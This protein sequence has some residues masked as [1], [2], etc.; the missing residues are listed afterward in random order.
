MTATAILCM[1]AAGIPVSSS[2]E[3]VGAVSEATPLADSTSGEALGHV[4]V[5][6][7]PHYSKFTAIVNSLL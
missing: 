7:D 5:G 6:G 2:H 4:L 1:T 3:S